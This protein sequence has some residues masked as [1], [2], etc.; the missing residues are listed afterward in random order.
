MSQES[1]ESMDFQS[2]TDGDTNNWRKLFTQATRQKD[3]ALGLLRH[4]NLAESI[5][6]LEQRP[7]VSII[8]L[9]NGY[10]LYLKNSKC[11]SHK[12]AA[13]LEGYIDNLKDCEERWKTL[14]NCFHVWT[15]AIT[16]NYL[17]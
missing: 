6:I 15:M 2:T 5:V 7:L 16:L 17:C 13:T 12:V 3:T 14:D 8:Y 9:W 1:V 11:S 4:G 10:T